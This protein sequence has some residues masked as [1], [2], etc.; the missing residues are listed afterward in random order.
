MNTETLLTLIDRRREEL[1]SLL[2]EL[3]QID[4]QNF[5]ET[6]REEP[7]A[8]HIAALCR[9]MG[10]QTEVY[11]PLEV[12]GLSESEDYVP[13]RNLERRFNVTARLAGER[14][15]DALMLMGHSDTVPIGD[16]AVWKFPPLFGVVRDGKILGRGA[17]DDKYALAT[18]LFLLRLLTEAGFRPKKNLIFT[19]Y[20][21]E[22]YG[23]SHGA[24]AACMRYPCERI[25]N[26]DGK[27]FEIWQCAAAGQ[28]ACLT[29]HIK[30]G[31][32]SALS[33]ARLLPKVL[34]ALEG[35]GARR[36]AEMA[37]NPNYVG[38][39]TPEGAMRYMEVRAGQAGNDLNRGSV[40]FTYYTDKTE[41]EIYAEFDALCAALNR[42]LEPEGAVCDGVRG[43]T[44][45]F[46]YGFAPRDCAPIT[47][48][49]RAAAR[50]SGRELPVMG[51]CL[52]D[53]SVILK[54]GSPEA[55]GFGIGRGF[56]VDGG[57]H[58]PNE[59]I[60]CD[61]LVEYAGII[62]TYVLD[63]LG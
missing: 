6:G 42:E 34:T 17:C 47:D 55:F 29:Y 28:N 46:R 43:A 45:F 58:Q 14:N 22:E 4:S 33:A 31:Q 26:M 51:A 41:G 52:S 62:G 19:A 15:E 18:V 56:S 49:Q 21:D 44:R 40:L 23:G 1:F 61:R 10:L 48:M 50:A 32:E 53:L 8:E 20:S 63:F 2:C 12:P 27:D 38:S 39:Q 16:A 25:V 54:Y 9:K 35:F 37:V 60:E 13:G 3:V 59:Y 24:M 11:S 36:R 30:E 57:A 5:G 7:A